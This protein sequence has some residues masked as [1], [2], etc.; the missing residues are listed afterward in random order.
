[1]AV[2]SP[3]VRNCCLDQNDV[4]LGCFRTVKE[5][6]SWGKDTSTDQKVLVDALIRKENHR[7]KYGEVFK[8]RHDF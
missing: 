6:T 7:K 3:C 8:D 5:I 2:K 4:C 1:M